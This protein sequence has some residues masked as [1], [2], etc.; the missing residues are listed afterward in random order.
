MLLLLL[1]VVVQCILNC[2]ATK[3]QVLGASS[4]S[5]GFG[6]FCVLLLS[7]VTMHRVLLLGLHGLL[8]CR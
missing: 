5:N 7:S 2:C 6:M 1:L 8:L 3:D 4:S